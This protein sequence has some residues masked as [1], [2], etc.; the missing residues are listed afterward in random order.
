M[1]QNVANFGAG[2]QACF[3]AEP[4]KEFYRKEEFHTKEG[5]EYATYAV[6]KKAK[7]YSQNNNALALANSS[8][9]GN[10]QPGGAWG[11][12]HSGNAGQQFN[13]YGSAGGNS[14]V[15]VTQLRTNG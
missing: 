12:G 10:C 6:P 5:T 14:L 7:P 13:Q 8:C 11:G 2:V 15:A 9:Q 4:P 3:I 1:G